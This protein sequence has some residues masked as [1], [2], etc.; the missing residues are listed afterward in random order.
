MPAPTS[1]L[2]SVESAPS[3]TNAKHPG[4]S[5]NE[6]IYVPDDFKVKEGARLTENL[7]VGKALG[8]GLQVTLCFFSVYALLL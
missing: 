1:D 5:Q 3:S 8:V 2:T 6:Y 7:V 4:S